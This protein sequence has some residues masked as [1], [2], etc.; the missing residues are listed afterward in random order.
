[1]HNSTK[2]VE[3]IIIKSK[4]EFERALKEAVPY[5]FTKSECRNAKPFFQLFVVVAS[6]VLSQIFK[7]LVYRVKIALRAY[8][9]RFCAHHMHRADVH[10]EFDHELMA[11]LS[12]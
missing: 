1:M 2:T 8:L 5:V 11:C 7:H 12:P 10:N 3:E 6:L 4:Y 9:W